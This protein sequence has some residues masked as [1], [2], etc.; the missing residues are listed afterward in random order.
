MSLFRTVSIALVLGFAVAATTTPASACFFHKD[1]KVAAATHKH[2]I[3]GFFA[4]IFHCK[5]K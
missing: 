4:A 1:T 3:H 2:P 5:K